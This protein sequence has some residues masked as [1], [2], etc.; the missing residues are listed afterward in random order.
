MARVVAALESHASELG[1]TRPDPILGPP[2]LSVGRITGGVSV[3]VVPDRAEI[4]IDRRMI[5]GENP[6]T[7]RDRVRQAVLATLGSLDGVEFLPPWVVMPSLTPREDSKSIW[8]SRLTAAIR[9]VGGREPQVL[10]VPYGTD[11]GPLGE[12]GLPCFVFGPGDIAQA[13]TKDE[14][15]EL[16]Q[17]RLASDMYFE[18]ACEL[19]RN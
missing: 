1:R 10:G 7:C 17:I 4:E 6:E 9:R 14:W 15:V 16:N 18:M 19:G 13:H 3:N 11:A 5:P 2:S 8:I 12:T